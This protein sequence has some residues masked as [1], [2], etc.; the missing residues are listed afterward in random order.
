MKLSE[1]LGMGYEISPS[2]FRRLFAE[3]EV[4]RQFVLLP[5][6]ILVLE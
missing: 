6:L 1:T 2:P 5:Q 3:T 4:L